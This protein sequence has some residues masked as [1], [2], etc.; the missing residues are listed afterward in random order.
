MKSYPQ[1]SGQSI[2]NLLGINF[3]NQ[4]SH[5]LESQ[6]ELNQVKSYSG[7]AVNFIYS[8]ATPHLNQIN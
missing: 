4:Y 8:T 6:I 2:S 5:N 1:E 3:L 7:C